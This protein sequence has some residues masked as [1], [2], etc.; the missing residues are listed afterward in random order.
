MGFKVNIVGI[1]GTILVGYVS[2]YPNYV[3]NSPDVCSKMIPGHGPRPQ[4]TP[5]PY[6]IVL[7]KQ[8]VFGGNNLQVELKGKN[9]E[10]FKGFYIQARDQDGSPI[11]LFQSPNE[12]ESK[13]HTCF[14][15]KNNAIH[16]TN[17]NDKE[18]ITLYWKA[19]EAFVGKVKIVATCENYKTLFEKHT[20]G[21]RGFSKPPGIG[22]GTIKR[23]V[24]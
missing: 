22:L 15:V 14:G 2:C 20:L 6:E 12:N 7:N 4:T 21:F 23:K 17:R 18:S 24:P 5:S 16:H 13:A 19:P 11:G 8:S 10:K 3:P 1:I 9:G